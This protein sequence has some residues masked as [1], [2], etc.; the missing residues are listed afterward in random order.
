LK[1]LDKQKEEQEERSALKAEHNERIAQETLKARSDAQ[2][3]EA[4]AKVRAPIASTVPD[5]PRLL[6]CYSSHRAPSDG[7]TD[8]AAPGVSSHTHALPA[9][10]APRV[11]SAFTQVDSVERTLDANAAVEMSAVLVQGVITQ[12]CAPQVLQRLPR[13]ELLDLAA[14]LFTS[15]LSRA[16]L[17]EHAYNKLAENKAPSG[18][19]AGEL[20]RALAAYHP[21]P[22]GGPEERSSS[23]DDWT[24]PELAIAVPSVP[25]KEP[26]LGAAPAIITTRATITAEDH[27]KDV[28]DEGGE[29]HEP[30][31]G[32]DEAARLPQEQ[33][34]VG[35]DR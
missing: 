31:P 5:Q 10:H 20:L 16:K 8:Q 25:R 15:H 9:P 33:G 13:D 26:M 2:L 18:T 19:S 30:Q 12:L 4:E 22:I 24:S 34:A 14:V 27:H 23:D 1:A 21:Q 28:S 3:E 7:H 11:S 29:T 6:H 32:A 17:A 35:S